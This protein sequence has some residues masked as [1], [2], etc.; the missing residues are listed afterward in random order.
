MITF[1]EEKT[2]DNISLRANIL[3]RCYAHRTLE[4][5]SPIAHR[6]TQARAWHPHDC[7]SAAT[8]V[9]IIY[10]RRGSLC[11]KHLTI[12]MQSTNPHSWSRPASLPLAACTCMCMYAWILG[13][14]RVVVDPI[15]DDTQ[16]LIDDYILSDLDE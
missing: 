13:H 9:T 7:I 8:C 10:T 3:E 16:R 11:H 1:C 2:S 6:P 15:C 14:I 5:A 12:V 4:R